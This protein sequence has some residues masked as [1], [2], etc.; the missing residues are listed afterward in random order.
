MPVPYM[1]EGLTCSLTMAGA[2]S[3]MVCRSWRLLVAGLSAVLEE[4][5]DD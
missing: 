2:A 5:D 3:F 4:W 1:E